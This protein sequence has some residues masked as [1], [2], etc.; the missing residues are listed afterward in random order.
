MKIRH[1]ALTSPHWCPF[2]HD[3]NCPGV[4][5][6][7]FLVSLNLPV[8]FLPKCGQLGKWINWDEKKAKSRHILRWTGVYKLYE[9]DALSAYTVVC[10]WCELFYDSILTS[11]KG[12]AFQT[13]QYLA[14]KDITLIKHFIFNQ[15]SLVCLGGILF[16]FCSKLQGK[17]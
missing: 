14:A 9:N 7:C 3:S 12:T 1:E 8:P 6:L 10:S 13:T 17:F 15:N 5:F 2:S 4:L 16:W 11:Y